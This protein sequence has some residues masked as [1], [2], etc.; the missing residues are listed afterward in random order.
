MTHSAMAIHSFRFITVLLAVVSLVAPATGEVPLETSFQMKAEIKD[1]RMA[2]ERLHYSRKPIEEVDFEGLITDYMS[3]LDSS[4][5]Y[6]L[7]ADEQLWRLRFGKTLKNTYLDKNELYPAFYIFNQFESRVKERITW[8]RQRLESDLD[9]FSKGEYIYDREDPTWESTSQELDALWDLRL[10]NEILAE[11]VPEIRTRLDEHFGEGQ[12]PEIDLAV[13]GAIT[14]E[15]AL[16][17][18][19]REAKEKILTR[20]ERWGQRISEMKQAEVQEGFLTQLAQVFDPHSNFMSPDTSEEFGISIS[21][22]LIGIGAVLADENGFCIIRE[23]VDSGPA[24][25]SGELGAGDTIIAVAEGRNDFEDVVG[26]RLRDIV[27]LIRGKEDSLVRLKVLPSKG[28]REEKVV[29]IIRKRIKLEEKLASAEIHLVPSDDRIIPVGVITLPNFYGPTAGNPHSTRASEDVH[30]LIQKLKDQNAEGIIL[31]LRNNGGGLL[32]EAINVTGLFISTGP[33]VKVRNRSGEVEISRDFDPR[34]SWEGPL[35]VLTSRYSASASEIVAGALQ[36]YKRAL[37]IGDESTHGKGTVQTTF[38][39]PISVYDLYGSENSF[40]RPTFLDRVGRLIPTQTNRSG[41]PSMA[42]I[43]IAKYYLPDGSSTQIRGVVADIPLPSV[44]ELLP[45]RESDLTNPLAWDQ[46]DGYP[47]E[48]EKL[49]ANSYPYLQSTIISALN[50][51]SRER[52]E[53]LEEFQYLHESILNFKERYDRKAIPVDLV[54]RMNL[55]YRDEEKKRILQEVSDSLDQFS[56]AS[57][58]VPLKDLA[59]EEIVKADPFTSAVG[60]PD[61][62]MLNVDG[63]DEAIAEPDAD[64]KQEIDIHLRESIR[65]VGDWVD[66]ER[67]LNATLNDRQIALNSLDDTLKDIGFWDHLQSRRDIPLSN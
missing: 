45:I 3:R 21:N 25:K 39:L 40:A 18:W 43:T 57:I 6:F 61:E 16:D 59:P 29:S 34:I 38:A 62:S 65:I 48:A 1:M 8:I 42:K 63:T 41:I 46:I 56:F 55:I 9:L 22:E 60:M 31:D 10:T 30:R 64:S 53:K 50:V 35:A 2:M 23:L 49:L 20:Y 66:L 5:L 67:H 28:P 17:E 44:S 19:V 54:S 36:Y 27:R 24:A 12:V 33:V 52:Q 14:G 51:R 11:I 15:G 7:K 4:Y 26:K 13:I 37:V 58:K 47:I 32:E